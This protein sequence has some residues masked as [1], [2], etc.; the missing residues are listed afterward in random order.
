M[1][2]TVIV[3]AYLVGTIPFALWLSRRRG[4]ADLRHA[5][6]GNMGATNV[7]RTAGTTTGVSASVRIVLTPRSRSSCTRRRFS[8]ILN[9]SATLSAVIG[10]MP[11]MATR[12]SCVD[13][14]SAS[15]EA[16]PVTM[17]SAAS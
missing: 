1:N 3:I 13:E 2:V 12:A 8:S 10:P 11:S 5:G 14:A 4:G 7:L 15:S 9:Q 17:R 16:K 6:S